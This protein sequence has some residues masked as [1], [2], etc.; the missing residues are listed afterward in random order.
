MLCAV[1]EPNKSGKTNAPIWKSQRKLKNAPKPL[2]V[3]L[4]IPLDTTYGRQK[5]LGVLAYIRKHPGWQVAMSKG[6]PFLNQKEIARWQGDGII[7][8][9]YTDRQVAEALARGIPVVNT[10]GTKSGTELPT[11]G[12]DNEAIGALAADHLLKSGRKKFLFFGRNDLPYAVT[13]FKAFE[14]RIAAAGGE[15][16]AHWIGKLRDDELVVEPRLYVPILKKL[17]G[18]VAVFG[19]TDRIAFGLL[20]ACRALD[21][22][23]PNDVAIVGCN[24]D[25]ILCRLANPPLSSVDESPSAVGYHA[26]VLLD[27]LMKGKTPGEVYQLLPP[28]GLRVRESSDVLPIQNNDLAGALRFIRDHSH[29]I[30]GVNDVMCT[31]ILSRRTLEGLFLKGLGHGIYQEIRRVHIQRAQQL[32]RETTLPLLEIARQSGFNSLSRFDV[33]FRKLTGLPP[34]TY[35][36]KHGPG[37]E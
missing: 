2:K 9:Y 31:T 35:R 10:S 4:C 28:A 3:A 6:H 11:V 32:L 33:A 8:E 29:E 12:I 22:H 26:A 34:M 24:N 15:A 7:G 16:E 36:R 1:T 27:R 14:R 23:V 5:L 18:P 30:I 21:L 37:S 25:E 20:E 19:A 17:R 13:R